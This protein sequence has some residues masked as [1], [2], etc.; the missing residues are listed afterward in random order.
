MWLPL[1]KLKRTVF[2]KNKA[3][4]KMLRNKIWLS[5]LF[6][7]TANIIVGQQL[8]SSEPKGGFTKEELTALFGP[9]AQYG[10][11]MHKILYTTLDVKGLPD[12]ASGLL[13][14]PDRPNSIFPLLCVQH[15][16]VDSKTDVPS[17]LRGGYELAVVFGSFGY[18]TVAPDLLGLGESRGFHP[19]VHAASE[20]SASIDMLYAT[21]AYASQNNIL[22]NDQLFITGYSQGGHSAAALHRELERNFSQDFTVT[23]SAP[24]S[25]PY[26]I[27]GEMRR[28]ILSDEA[29]FFPAYVPNTLLSYD[30]VYDLF[31]SVAVAFKQPYAEW[32]EKYYEGIFTLGTLNDLLITKLTQDHGASISKYMF[33]DSVLNAVATN[34]DHPVNV[35]LRDNDLYNWAPQSPTRLFY[36][37]ADDQVIY[38]NSVVADSVMNLLGAPDVDAVDVNSTADHGECVVPAVTQAFLFFLQYQS[39]T[40]SVE[41]PDIASDIR[42]FPNPTSDRLTF[43]SLPDDAFL[44]LLDVNGKLVLHQKMNQPQLSVEQLP[45][46]IYFLRLNWPT[47]YWS[48]KIVKQ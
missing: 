35:A 38:L 20:A 3:L 23:A 10:V 18:V 41:Q 36:C 34:L 47:G 46:G 17:N 1:W 11:K 29:Y 25:G 7:W 21:R 12:T 13:I 6:F 43:V 30:L 32:I 14:V 31:D 27:S 24:M 9:F 2:E 15:G 26:S 5:V 45:P 33:Q 8:L 16:T 22:L 48:S 4:K 40:T 19:Y 39:I 37:K 42:V 28:L 44:Q